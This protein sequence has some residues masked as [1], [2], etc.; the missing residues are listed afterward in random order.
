MKIQ[1]PTTAL[2]VCL[3]CGDS[4]ADGDPPAAGQTTIH[5]CTVPDATGPGTAATQM[6]TESIGSETGNLSSESE[7]I[8][9]ETGNSQTETSE[10]GSDLDCTAFEACWGERWKDAFGL[11]G[12]DTNP[13][14][15]VVYWQ[16]CAIAEIPCDRVACGIDCESEREAI[17]W[18]CANNW[19]ECDERRSHLLLE[20]VCQTE[21]ADREVL[22]D[23]GCIDID[24][25]DCHR[26]ANIARM[27]CLEGSR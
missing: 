14:C 15:T 5:N 24:P 9:S 25:I 6:S 4:S 19:P 8:G 20:D 10:I 21:F 18:D 2:L 12:Y 7:S 26:D 27:H 1:I 13:D 17:E 3:A 11:D 23:V 16:F 22:C